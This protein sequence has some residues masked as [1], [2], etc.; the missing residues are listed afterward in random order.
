MR[1]SE[2]GGNYT[3]NNS[4]NLIGT[5]AANTGSVNLI[6]NGAVTI[7]AVGGVTGWTTTGNSTLT[8][9]GSTSDIVVSN[10]VNWG[11]SSLTLNAGRNVA[12]NANMTG[13][14]AGDLTALANGNLTIGAA[15]SISGKTIALSASGAFTN[16]RGSDAVSASDRWLVYSSAPNAPGQNFGNLNS[17]NTAIWGNTFVTLPPASVTLPGNRY[18]FATPATLTVTSL[19]DSKTYGSTANLSLYTVTGFQAGVPNAFLGDPTNVSGTPGFFSVGTPATTDVG[20]Y[21]II[22]S[23]GTLSA[24]NG[25]TFAFNSTGLLT[26]NPQALTI[27]ANNVTQFYNNVPYSGGNG[28]TYNG[29]VT[30]QNS[31]VLSGT[32]TYGGNS[33]GAVNVGTYTIIPSGQTSSNYAITYVGGTL[34]ITPPPITVVLDAGRTAA[35]AAGPTSPSLVMNATVLPSP[36]SLPGNVTFGS[37]TVLPYGNDAGVVGGSTSQQTSNTR[38][39]NTSVDLKRR[40]ILAR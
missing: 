34:T 36:T 21:A 40:R 18:I 22:V 2:P 11:N 28:V 5:V 19:N 30:G 37:N 33:Q 8:A 1:C 39:S 17:N 35:N 15:G 32:I 20:N 4:G 23:Q 10:A 16:N 6:S 14:T 3:L 25:Y 27:S 26:V 12:I 24:T 31:L 38:T 7:G 13:G 29:F 9:I